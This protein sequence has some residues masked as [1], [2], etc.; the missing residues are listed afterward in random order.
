V[1][2]VFTLYVDGALAGRVTPSLTGAKLS[3]NNK[4]TYFGADVWTASQCFCGLLD[5][6]RLYNREVSDSEIVLLAAEGTPVVV[7]PPHSSV[8]GFGISVRRVEGS[9]VFL[10][11]TSSPAACAAIYDV[12]GR[13]LRRLAPQDR[14]VGVFIWDAASQNGIPAADGMYFVKAS[15]PQAGTRTAA[16]VLSRCR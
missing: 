7:R 16:F 11:S 4:T 10:I 12:R 8:E 13:Y 15:S 6:V 3:T 5:D 1:K 2:P 14:S 9:A